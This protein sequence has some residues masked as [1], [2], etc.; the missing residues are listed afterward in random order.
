MLLRK[1]AQNHVDGAVAIFASHIADGDLRSNL[2]L[3]TLEPG[4]DR[5]DERFGR[6]ILAKD[7]AVDGQALVIDG[8]YRSRKELIFGRSGSRL[9]GVLRVCRTDHAAG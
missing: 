7:S 4:I 9:N 1:A 3:A 8:G 6:R 5:K 2:G